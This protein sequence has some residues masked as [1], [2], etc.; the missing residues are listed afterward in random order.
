MVFQM[1][2]LDLLAAFRLVVVYGGG[3]TKLISFKNYLVYTNSLL[4]IDSGGNSRLAGIMLAAATFGILLVGPIV[5]GYIPIMVVGALIFLLGIELLEEALKDTW[6]RVHKLEYLT[7][8]LFSP[9]SH[10]ELT[11]T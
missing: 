2:S 5:I 1:H 8:S 3:Y 7:V 9:R 6:G 10:L 11:L 4:F